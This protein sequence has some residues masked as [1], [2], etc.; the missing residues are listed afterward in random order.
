MQGP[1]TDGP[2]ASGFAATGEN[3]P[4]EMIRQAQ[5]SRGDKNQKFGVLQRFLP[6]PE[7]VSRDWDFSKARQSGDGAGLFRIGK[8]A[9]HGRFVIF[10]ANGLRQRAVGDDGY[11]VHAGAS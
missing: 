9:K 10:D 7:R 5:F 4:R 8:T 2:T 6:P 1:W 11:P 3:R